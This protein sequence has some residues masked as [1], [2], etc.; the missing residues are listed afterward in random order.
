MYREKASKH[1]LPHIH[2]KYSGYEITMTF[3]GEVLNGTMPKKQ[4]KL[5]QAWCAIHEESLVANWNLLIEKGQSFKIEPL[6]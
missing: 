6:K 1:N 2:A 3:D 5:I 4:L